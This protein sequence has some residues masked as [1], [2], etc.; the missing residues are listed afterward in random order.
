MTGKIGLSLG[1][2]KSQVAESAVTNAIKT[3]N[4][5]ETITE[6]RNPHTRSRKL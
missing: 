3:V 1:T 5:T 2:K 4:T 6:R